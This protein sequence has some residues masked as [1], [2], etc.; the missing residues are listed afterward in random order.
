MYSMFVKRVKLHL[1]CGSNVKEGYINIDKFIQ[2][3]NINN[4]D[5]LKLPFSDKSCDEI[6]AEHIVE[7]LSFSEE[8]QFFAKP[9]GC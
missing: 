1:G 2:G 3:P 6:L 5:I 8:K 7:H 9:R 4:F